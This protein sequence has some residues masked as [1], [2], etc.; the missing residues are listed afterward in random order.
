MK[1]FSA[2]DGVGMQPAAPRG[3]RRRLDHRQPGAGGRRIARAASASTHVLLDVADKLAAW[4][5]LR[6]QLGIAAEA[7]AHIGDD[8]PTC[9]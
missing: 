7:C 6:A 5:A 1:A 8:L 2:L 4:H 9:R 3:H